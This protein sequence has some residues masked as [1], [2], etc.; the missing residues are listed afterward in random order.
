[1]KK[2]K[3]L[4]CAV[5]I[6]ALSGILSGCRLFSASE[7]LLI[8]PR[9]QGELSEIQER[10]RESFGSSIKLKY[11]TDG[12]YRSAIISYDL[13]GNGVND[14]IAFYSTESDNISAMHI[15]V[16]TKRDGKWEASKDI[17]VLASGVEQVRFDDLDGDGVSEIIVGWNIYGNVDK[18]VAVYSFDGELLTQRINEK[19]SEFLCCDLDTNQKK[20]LFVLHLNS[21]DKKATAKLLE[22]NEGSGATELSSCRSDGNVSGYSSVVESKLLNGKPA[23]FV[24]GQKGGSTLTEIMYLENGSLVNP[25]CDIQTFVTT[26]TERASG[27]SAKDINGDGSLDI[28]MIQLLPGYEHAAEKDKLYVTKWCAYDGVKLVV[29]MTAVMNYTDGYYFTVPKALDGRITVDKNVESRT[30]TIYLYDGVTA[31]RAGELFRIRT[32]NINNWESSPADYADWQEIASNESVVYAVKM[33]GYI[34]EGALTLDQIKAEFKLI[35]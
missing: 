21:T 12:D 13:T 11:P 5:L 31:A 29:T 18:E 3:I 4:L 17:A 19:Y 23:I 16:V 35:G 9:P 30:R 15:S 14:A 2:L 22:L 34:G 28:P 33:G 24:D 6:F 10:L 26:V 20:E 7:D 8:P 32:V 27:V 25:F 1:M